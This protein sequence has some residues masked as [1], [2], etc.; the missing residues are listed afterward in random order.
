MASKMSIYS[1]FEPLKMGDFLESCKW[2]AVSLLVILSGHLV[3][4]WSRAGESIHSYWFLFFLFPTGSASDNNEIMGN[5]S[6]RRTVSWLRISSAG[7]V[8][9]S[10][11]V[12]NKTSASSWSATLIY[13]AFTLVE[14]VDHPWL[15]IRGGK[16]WAHITPQCPAHKAAR[17]NSGV[18]FPSLSVC[19]RSVY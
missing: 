6:F 3:R 16:N 18:I 8:C 7:I 4:D 9:T 1:T 12:K 14:S 19:V 10:K 11:K 13:L 17:D 5:E 2:L 15:Y